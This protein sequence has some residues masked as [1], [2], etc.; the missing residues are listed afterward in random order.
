MRILFVVPYAPTLIRTRPYNLLRA[1]S[2]RGHAL[3]LATVWETEPERQALAAFAETGVCLLARPLTRA[4]LARNA[5]QALLGP[6]PLQSRYCWAPALA[7]LIAETLASAPEPFDVVHVE[8]LRGADYGLHA[9]QQLRRLGYRT[10]VIWDSVD[11]ISLLFEQTARFSRSRVG[12]LMAHFELPRTRRYEAALARRFEAVLATSPRDGAALEALSR[13]PNRSRLS[14]GARPG[15]ARVAVLPNGVDSDYFHVVP[16]RERQGAE[17]VILTGKM[18]YHANV[19]AALHLVNHI[20]PRVWERR[21]TAQ[22]VIAGSA[23]PPAVRVLAA[24]HAP[25]VLV[26]GYV[27]DLRPFLASAAVAVAPVTYG[28]GIQNKTLEAMASGLPVVASPQA[29]SALQAR[30]GHDLLVADTDERFA[31]F[32]VQLLETPIL[33]EQVGLAGREYVVKYHRWDGIASQLESVYHQCLAVA[34]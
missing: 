27:P 34:A 15:P 23:P 33:R 31:D 21:P 4:Q 18:S 13:R 6:N 1:L 24:R 17:Q 9:Q 16:R 25:R 20:M 28:A 22:V 26:T 12:R 7:H 14:A 3:T 8:H 2:A 32:I 11:C 29:N 30:A 10:P 5:V 19:T